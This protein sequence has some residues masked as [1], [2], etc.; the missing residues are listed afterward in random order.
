M[1]EPT[2]ILT[3][4][5]DR[6]GLITLSR[7]KALN[8]LNTELMTEVV[9]AVT[10]FDDDPGIGA[11]VITGSDRAFAAGADIKEMSDKSFS[12]MVAARFFGAWDA[13][14][15]SRTPTIAAVN[16]YALG[17]GCELAMLCD[18]IIAGDTAVFGQPEID[19]GVIPG[20]G[21]SQRLTRAIG[22]AKAMDMILTG[23]RMSA[24]EADRL[25]LQWRSAGR[26][27][28]IAT[29]QGSATTHQTSRP[30]GWARRSASRQRR[31]ASSQGTTTSSGS[32]TPISPLERKARPLASQPSSSARRSTR[33]GSSSASSQPAG[34]LIVKWRP[35]AASTWRPSN[36][37]AA[38]YLPETPSRSPTAKSAG[39]R[40]SSGLWCG[41]PKPPDLYLAPRDA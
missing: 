13:L 26:P 35:I 28:G 21:G 10:A 22:K 25:G 8:A 5:R 12:D 17:G 39:V 27:V 3:E 37:S 18:L 11:I 15:N 19:L 30:S 41:W 23:R 14:A 7:P 1:P 20:I 4:T 40:G 32:T 24:D 6:V 34:A 36:L 9:A 31:C 33:P 2:T 29:A 38:T 16:G